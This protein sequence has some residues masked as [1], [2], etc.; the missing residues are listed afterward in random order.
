MK[1]LLLCY[2][3]R[4]FDKKS[5]DPGFAYISICGTI[6]SG[7]KHK[8]DPDFFNVLNLDFDDI[9]EEEIPWG[10]YVLKGISDSDAEAVVK[11]IEKNKDKNFMIHC[12]AGQSRSQAIIRYVLDFYG[13][14]DEWEINKDN[15]PITPNQF[16][17]SKFKRSYYN[18]LTK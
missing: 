3:K 5:G 17:L 6:D 14:E 15:P 16:V 11:F 10:N 9:G 12:R 1:K 13:G 4:E 7:E 8:L 18:I 2:G